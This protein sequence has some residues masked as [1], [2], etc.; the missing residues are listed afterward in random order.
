ML[1][2]DID[3]RCLDSSF[4]KISETCCSK[5]SPSRGGNKPATTLL[6]FMIKSLSSHYSDMIAAIPIH[7]LNLEELKKNCI[8]VLK[9][10]MDCGFNVI[11]L[12]CDNH[13]VNCSFF[14]FLSG[15]AINSSCSNP[16]DENKKMFLLIDPVHTIKNIY[17]NFQ[18][19]SAFL[20]HDSS[21]FSHA[22]FNHVKALYEIESDMALRKAHK[23]NKIVMNPTNIQ[24][25]SAKLAFAL[26][27]D[28][29]IATFMYYTD[30]DH[31]EWSNTAKF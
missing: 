28:S 15:G 1:Q 23:L 19:R 16:L 11:A 5:V 27:H 26:F 29:T 21:L 8:E 10:V 14:N 17:N 13:P 25:T 2:G 18:K 9:T 6:C 12:C 30:T 7:S 4:F 22:D 31:P 24:R 3:R 20:F